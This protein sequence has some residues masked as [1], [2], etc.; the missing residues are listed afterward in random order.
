VAAL[1]Q[2]QPSRSVRG[3]G[4]GAAT[5]LD[6]DVAHVHV[7]GAWADEQ[8]S[9]ELAVGPPDRDEAEHLELTSRQS[10]V[11]ELVRRSSTE[12]PIDLLAEARQLLSCNGRDRRARSRRAAR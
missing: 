1:D 4:A 7:D 11:L 9:G 12:S 8:R 10:G 6:Q 2:T 3:F 5:E